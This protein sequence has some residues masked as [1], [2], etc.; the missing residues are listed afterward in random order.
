MATPLIIVGES[1]RAAAKSA[2]LAGFQPWR[3]DRFVTRDLKDL[4]S[5]R[6]CP[7]DRFPT[8][9]L[10]L[11]ED[12]PPDASV[13]Y[14]APLENHPELLEAIAFDR[15]L[16]GCS[17]NAVRQVRDPLALANLP[18]VRGLKFPKVWRSASL[19]ARLDRAISTLWG[20]RQYLAKPQA[21]WGGRNIN[22]WSLAQRSNHD[23]YLQQYLHGMP[24]SAVYVADGWS[25]QLSG[26]T[27]QLIGKRSFG[28]ERFRY[29]G[30]VGPINL[31]DK[32]RHALMHLGVVLTQR[33]D[34][35]GIF[36]IDAIMDRR[37]QIWP[38]EVNPR[39][40]DSVEL[41]EQ[42]TNLPLLAT[43]QVDHAAPISKRRPRTRGQRF[44]AK[45]ILYTKTH[46]SIADPD[47]EFDS[48]QL[49]D[50]PMSNALIPPATPLCTLHVT[51][52]TRDDCLKQL[53]DRAEKLYR[54]ITTEKPPT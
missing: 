50:L 42:T 33:F 29:C 35:R 12:A 11:L 30:S 49:T 37:G 31:S 48:D 53:H 10:E 4:G 27:E 22:F 23:F 20:G 41:L 5:V 17:A 26:V 34:L 6:Q 40:T 47:T 44:C 36:G 45:S 43:H 46:T 54:C 28:A 51:A 8:A 21:S 16:L 18:T 13:L 19:R 9:I 2:L 24:I 25:A 3:I 52:S 38:V 7:T 15:P 14:T 1:T 32:Q 39:Y